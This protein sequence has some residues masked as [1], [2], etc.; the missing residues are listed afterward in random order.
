MLCASMYN[1]LTCALANK[2]ESFL[3]RSI[4]YQVSW[5]LSLAVLCIPILYPMY[6][7]FLLVTPQ[8]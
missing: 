7:P 1:V 8:K 4:M 3:I 6:P 5:I 2:M